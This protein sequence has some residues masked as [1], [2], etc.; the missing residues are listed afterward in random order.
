MLIAK[1]VHNGI[2]MSERFRALLAEWKIADGR[3]AEAQHALNA[4]FQA[5]IDGSGPEP[6][7]SE[8]QEVERLRMKANAAL[9]VALSYV[10]ET[11]R[12][13]ASRK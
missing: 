3:A 11:A 2:P 12:G 6:S 10:R 1:P 7:E 4:K 5:F 13:P 9:E 8:R